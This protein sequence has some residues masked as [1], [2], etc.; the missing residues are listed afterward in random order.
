[1]SG[2]EG[3]E[4]PHERT[5]P[6]VRP[7]RT[8]ARQVQEGGDLTLEAT[9]GYDPDDPWA[10]RAHFRD[11]RGGSVVWELS[12][13][14]LRSGTHMP[15]G[16]GDVRLW[17]LYQGRRGGRVR[18]LLGPPGARALV[19]VDRAALRR[20][21]GETYAAV[22]DGGEAGRIDWKAETTLLLGQGG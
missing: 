5:S 22:P 6:R 2:T 9:F 8:T 18:M 20:W 3:R 11:A 7:W 21:L 4:N 17:P 1:M 13:E 10:I 14:L 15:S 16:R 19:D 12:R